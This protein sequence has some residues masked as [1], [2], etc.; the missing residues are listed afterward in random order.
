MVYNPSLGQVV[1]FGGTP[2]PPQAFGDTWA[3]N[4]KTWTRLN[5]SS[6]P[7]SRWNSNLVFDLL[8]DGLFLVGGEMAEEEI[9]NDTWLPAP[10]AVP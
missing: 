9:G 7:S 2:D 8:N 10:V 4:G 5:F 1:M 6:H 3:W